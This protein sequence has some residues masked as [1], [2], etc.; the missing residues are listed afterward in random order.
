MYKHIIDPYIS[1]KDM[2]E[3]QYERGDPNTAN[4]A[5]EYQGK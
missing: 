4:S 1:V 3:T 2:I 5:L